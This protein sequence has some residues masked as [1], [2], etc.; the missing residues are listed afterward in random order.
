MVRFRVDLKFGV[1]K[2]AQNGLLVA[3]WNIT[4]GGF[5]KL[6]WGFRGVG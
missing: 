3:L 6:E 4:V 2:V 1:V 5:Q